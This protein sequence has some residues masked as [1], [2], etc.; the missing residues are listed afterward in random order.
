MIPFTIPFVAFRNIECCS[1][2]SLCCA[3]VFGLD[4]EHDDSNR[5]GSA[6]KCLSLG[7]VASVSAP[8]LISSQAVCAVGLDAMFLERWDAW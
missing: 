3:A 2:R 7:G 1:S 8:L 5:I 4:L 6:H